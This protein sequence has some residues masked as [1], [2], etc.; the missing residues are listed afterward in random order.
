MLYPAARF[1]LSLVGADTE[2]EAYWTAAINDP[3]LP[4]N[5]RKDLIE[6]LNEDGLSDAKHPGPEDLTLISNRIKLIEDLAPFA[7]DQ[8][9]AK[10]FAEAHKDLM[11]LANGQP[12]Q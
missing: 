3:N 1:S 4:A 11:N 12:L 8:V 7:M 6:D 10:A 2:A 5:E 9:N